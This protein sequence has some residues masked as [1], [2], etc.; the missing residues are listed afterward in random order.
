MSYDPTYE[1]PKIVK[2]IETESRIVITSGWEE[3]VMASYYLMATVSVWDDEEVLEPWPGSS[4][5]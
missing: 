3:R 5:G 4:G 1:I 2:F